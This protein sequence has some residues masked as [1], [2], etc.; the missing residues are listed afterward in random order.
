MQL[1]RLL[2]FLSLSLCWL[3][4]ATATVVEPLDLATLAAE[5]SHVVHGRVGHVYT[6]PERGPRG[7]I[8][9]QAEISVVQYIIGDGPSQLVVQQLGGQL[10][11]WRMVLS[12]N[13]EFRPGAEVVVFL[14]ADP[15]RGLHYVVGLAQGLFTV[16]RSG[17]YP[18]LT[19]DLTGLS[20][21]LAEPV[22]YRPVEIELELGRLIHLVR[23]TVTG[24]DGS[25]GFGGELR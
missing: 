5:S 12:G 9:T 18:N 24:P 16:D 2:A 4:T 10:G 25:N 8:Y 17:A 7:E 11:E 20:F 23:P 14:D 15:E 1:K 21:Y 22:P 19:R 3:S 13:A 6:V